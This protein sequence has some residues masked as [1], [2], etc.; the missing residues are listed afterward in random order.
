[1]RSAIDCLRHAKHCEDLAH[2]CGSEAAKTVLLN[3][4]RH[5]R[6]L[7]LQAKRPESEPEEHKG[8]PPKTA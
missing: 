7:A 1:M 3:T 5:W 4:A 6:N 2:V 8:P